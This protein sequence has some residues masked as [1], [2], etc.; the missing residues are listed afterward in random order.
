MFLSE[1][2][3]ILFQ[4]GEEVVE[5]IYLHVTAIVGDS[6]VENVIS[7]IADLEGISDL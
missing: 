5:G 6:D 2:E 1:E 3:E 7:A 4:R